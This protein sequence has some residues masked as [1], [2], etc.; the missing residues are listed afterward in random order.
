MILTAVGWQKIQGSVRARDEPVKTG[1]DK[2][3]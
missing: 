1:S 2:D 3:G